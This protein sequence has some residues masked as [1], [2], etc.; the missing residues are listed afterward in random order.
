MLPL[1]ESRMEAFPRPE[2]PADRTA[3]PSAAAAPSLMAASDLEQAPVRSSLLRWLASA[4]VG[5]AFTLAAALAVSRGWVEPSLTLAAGLLAPAL[6][7]GLI[8]GVLEWRASSLLRAVDEVIVVGAVLVYAT[9]AL[10][11]LVRG[12]SVDFT[13]GI[14]MPLAVLVTVW[15]ARSIESLIT[16]R[17]ES[18][19]ELAP[20]HE[21]GTVA[22]LV[23]DPSRFGRSRAS[24]RAALISGILTLAALP[25]AMLVLLVSW[26]VSGRIGVASHWTLAAAVALSLAPRLFRNAMPAVLASCLLGARRLGVLFSA[27]RALEKA[28]L[29]DGVVLRKQG[30][31]VEGGSEVIEFHGLG[32]LPE[33]TVLA[34]LASCEEIASGNEV[35]EALMRH[36]RREGVKPGDTRMARHHPS[37]GIHSTSPFGEIFVGNRLFLIENGISVG[38]GETVASE[39]EKRG[40]TAVFV[41][42]NRN[43][44]AVAIL[45]NRLRASSKP[46]VDGCHAL[47]LTTVFVTGD[48]FRTAESIG[49]AL[50]V[51]QIRAEVALSGREAEIER[52]RSTGLRLAIFGSLA[53]GPPRGSVEEDLAIGLGWDGES[54]ADPAWDV[55]VEGDDLERAARALAIARRGRRYLLATWTLAIL[56]G[57]VTFGFAASGLASP[58]VAALA[59]NLASAVMIAMRPSPAGPR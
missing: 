34:L 28:G 24:R 32:E 35:A 51:D 27:D 56:A 1:L 33:E 10:V 44:E 17:L 2:R 30:V 59:V 37:R 58:L 15:A 39:A 3:D 26:L 52:L 47:G 53:G 4:L 41:S 43:V 8:N 23:G 21:P 54:G 45:S 25:A 55:L 38:R 12:E 49:T 57:G 7:L 31:V 36:A 6:L 40:H 5:G 46:T 48:S 20:L 50:N 18:D 14:L 16:G 11:A 13:G 29:V 19:S 22:R 9:P 42:I